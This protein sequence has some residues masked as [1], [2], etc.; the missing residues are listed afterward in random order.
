MS[1]MSLHGEEEGKGLGAAPQNSLQD[2][3]EATWHVSMLQR[4]DSALLFSLTTVCT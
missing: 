2:Q 4:R 1:R 3:E